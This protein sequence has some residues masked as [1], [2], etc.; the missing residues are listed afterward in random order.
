M[1]APYWSISMI[2]RV[3]KRWCRASISKVP[4]I[5]KI[6]IILC[7]ILKTNLTAWNKRCCKIS[8]W[9]LIDRY[10]TCYRVF[11]SSGMRDNKFYWIS[12]TW[13]WVRI[14]KS[15]IRIW[16]GRIITITKIPVTSKSTGWS[17]CSICEIYGC[18]IRSIVEIKSPSYRALWI[19]IWDDKK[20]NN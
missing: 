10:I 14:R 1:C 17:C 9:D 18:A 16:E 5:C 8:N 19:S 6:W 13:I 3:L 12:L 20:R 7:V 15:I 11:T 4:Q 2:S